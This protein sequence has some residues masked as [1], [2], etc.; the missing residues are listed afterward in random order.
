MKKLFFITFI[1]IGILYSCNKDEFIEN[2]SENKIDYFTLN[3]SIDKQI[4]T[5][6]TLTVKSNVEENYLK[7]FKTK[8]KSLNANKSAQH[9]TT[10]KITLDPHYNQEESQFMLS[11]YQDLANCYDNKII[12]LLNSKRI[13]LNNSNFSL[14]FK[15]EANF[16]FSTIEKT[17]NEIG[18]ILNKSQTSK[19]GKAAGFGDCFA[20]KGKGIGRAVATGALVGAAGGTVALPGIGTASGAIGGA[21]FGA[22]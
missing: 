8:P 9:E 2:K 12:E 15:N 13:S 20:T 16:I 19:T 17:T 5:L 21:V 11:F 3:K 4:S 6:R 7:Y 18:A 1:L 14:D 22:A 10:I